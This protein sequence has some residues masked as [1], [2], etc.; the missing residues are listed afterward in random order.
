[1]TADAVVLVHGWGGSFAATWEATGFTLLLEEA[2]KRVIGVDLLG[3]GTAP[4]PTDPAAYHDLGARVLDALPADPVAA[5]GF[6]LGA[7]TLLRLATQVPGRFDRLVLAGIGEGTMQPDRRRHELILEALEAPPEAVSE[8]DPWGRM[9]RQYAEQ[10]GNDPVALAALMRSEP[11][12]DLSDED[13]ARVT[14]P[15]LLVVGDQDFAGPAEPLAARLPSAQVTV[16]RHVDHFATTEA[17]GFLD[18]ALGFL[19]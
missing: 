14:C 1:V 5:I 9:F 7:V 18:A 3:H 19:T 12:L 16:L 8:L 15:V 4:K 13:L 11:S 10:P 17:F 6:S 2:G